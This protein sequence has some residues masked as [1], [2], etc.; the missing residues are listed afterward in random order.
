[1]TAIG[2]DGLLDRYQ[3]SLV[4]ILSSVYPEYEWLPWKFEKSTQNFW[5]SVNNQK[6]FMD[7]AAKK[8]NIK[9]MSDWYKV[10]LKVTIATLSS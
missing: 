1:L 3:G 7:W 10:S 9:E 6:R 2:G 4:N 8:L 5:E